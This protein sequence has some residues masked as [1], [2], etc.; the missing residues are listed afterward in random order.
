MTPRRIKLKSNGDKRKSQMALDGVWA[1]AGSLSGRLT[2][3]GSWPV[4]QNQLPS[5]RLGTLPG[6]RENWARHLTR[7][8]ENFWGSGEPEE[9]EVAANETHHK[10]S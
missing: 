6:G 1:L 4:S 9:E 7:E 8:T 10:S 3:P 5:Q 2:N